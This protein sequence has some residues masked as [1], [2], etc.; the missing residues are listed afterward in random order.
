M[1]ANPPFRL[2]S[3]AEPGPTLRAFSVR[4][5]D[6]VRRVMSAVFFCGIG[7]LYLSF[8]TKNYY[9]DGISFASAIE[10][11][12]RFNSSLIH[13]HHLLY[14]AF[15]FVIYRFTGLL[16]FR[17]RAIEVLQFTNCILSLCCAVLLAR[18]LQRALQSYF[19]TVVLTAA[20]SFS[21]TWW[22]YSTDADSYVLSVLFL[23]F[24]LNLL[25]ASGKVRSVPLA[26]AHVAG[27]CFHQLA[28]FFFPAVIVGI[29]LQ[30]ISL[31]ERVRIAVQ[32]T[33]LASSMILALNYL[34]FH[35]STG[36]FGI[37]DFWRWLTLYVQGPDAYSFSFD[38]L[39]NFR[40]TLRGAIRLFFEGRLKWIRGL[41]TVPVVLLIALLAGIVFTLGLRFIRGIAAIKRP[42]NI[43]GAIDREFRPLFY[44][45]GV[46]SITYLGFLFF[47]YPYFTPYR[48][49]YLPAV[50]CL[51]G[52]WLVQKQRH[53]PALPMTVLLLVAGMTIS[54]FVF[55]VLPMT[56][57]EKYPPLAFALQMNESWSP[58]TTVY[59]ATSN[60]D[61][62]LV[63]YFSPSTTWK[64]LAAG[65]EQSIENELQQSYQYGGTTWLETSA[66]DELEH[67][68]AGTAWLS[69][70]AARVNCRKELIDG[71]YRLKFV[72]IF[73][74]DVDVN[75]LADCRPELH[76]AKDSFK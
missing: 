5:P 76:V 20:F 9:W 30:K 32:Y 3:V 63:R 61:N 1:S 46:W 33:V 52:V 62:Q 59:F 36:S 60:A 17:F 23:L 7:L 26:F 22:K 45:C 44:V 69:T 35:L 55:F 34:C 12:T 6:L 58:K 25:L 11:S 71:Q 42:L 18:F 10:N 2:A 67:S 4:H 38:L 68:S 64:K 49:F 75:L 57:S 37:P 27:M 16:G 74:I 21:S 65:D 53:N 73:P 19:I 15:G 47:W 48:L 8:P 54:N 50:I 43:A 41:V 51:L 14:N 56:H 70:H 66:I 29:F 28:V 72:Q 40:F 13:P 39:N 24:A 31:R